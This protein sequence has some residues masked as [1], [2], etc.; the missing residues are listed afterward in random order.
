M[1]NSC[2]RPG[3][4]FAVT[5]GM[6]C[7]NC[8]GWFHETCTY[9]T[10]A[11]YSRLSKS[12]RRWV[13]VTCNT[14]TVVMLGTIITLLTGLRDKLSKNSVNDSIMTG[15]KAGTHRANKKKDTD[16]SVIDG[17]VNSTSDDVLKLSTILTSTVIDSLSKLGSPRER[18]LNETVVPKN[19][20]GGWTHVNRSNKA[21]ASPPKLNVPSI[22]RKSIDA[23]A[24]QSTPKTVRPV[25]TE[26]RNRKR[27]STSKQQDTKPRR[28]GKPGKSITV[29]DDSVIIMNLID[30]PDLPLSLQ[31]KNDRMLWGEL[32]KRLELPRIEPLT[33]TRLTRG[34]DSNHLNHPRLLRVTLKNA[35][36]VEDVLLASHLLKSDGNVRILPDIPYSERN[37]IRNIPKESREAFFRGRNIIVQGVPENMDPTQANSDIREWKF[38]KH[39]LKLKNILTQQVMR[40]AKRD[41]DSRPRLL[42]ITFPSSHM[43]AA[44]LEAFRANR[45]RLPTGIHMHPDRPHDSRIKHK[46]KLELTIPLVDCLDHKKNV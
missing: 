11:A 30:N 10:A 13:C 20:V 14:D 28:P 43:A 46:R 15:N 34:K 23:L 27:A 21:Q 33:V 25:I 44:T 38:I 1:K 42:K 29:R 5:S 39:S 8:K 9:L 4:R 16:R 45:R 32:N 35:S 2:K 37:L 24:A 18:S 40:L 7:D 6:Q 12:D 17:A 26:P 36:D 31:D 22:V 19:P 41:G 3:C